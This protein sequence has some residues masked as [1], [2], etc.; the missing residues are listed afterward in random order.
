[1]RV[2]GFDLDV[3]MDVKRVGLVVHAAFG[4]GDVLV[5]GAGG[6]LDFDEQGLESLIFR[7]AQ[8]DFVF[9]LLDVLLA[10]TL[11]RGDLGGSLFKLTVHGFETGLLS[12][13]LRLEGMNLLLNVP[14]G[15]LSFVDSVVREFEGFQQRVAFRNKVLGHS[16]G[17]VI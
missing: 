7:Q 12:V 9:E 16:E 15:F 13:K 4:G 10:M 6:G 5:V 3:R 1:M 17:E 11:A 14:A 8:A 2:G